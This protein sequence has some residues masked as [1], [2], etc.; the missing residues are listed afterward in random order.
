M[1]QI[2]L[3]PLRIPAG[4][5]VSYNG[6]FEID[7][8]PELFPDRI[9]SDLFK[10]DMLQMNNDRADRLLDVGW[11]P[12]GDLVDGNYCVVVYEGDFSGR[13][14]YELITRD[15]LEL[16]ATIERLLSEICHGKL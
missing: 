12:D 2:P 9:P 3:Q 14:I 4:W 13:L 10:E 7:P 1:V 16:V 5:D 11:Y 15:R 8:L 6:L